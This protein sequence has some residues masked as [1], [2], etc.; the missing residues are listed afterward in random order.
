MKIYKNACKV[1]LIISL[2]I[3]APFYAQAQSK[4]PSEEF[5]IRGFHLDLRIQV[6]TPKALKAFADELSTMGMNTIVMEWEGTYPFKKHAVIANKYSYSRE[7]VKD[8]IDYCDNLGIQVIPLQQSLGHAEYILRN[9][10][11]SDLKAD[12]KDI[13]QINPLKMAESK[14]LFTDLFSDM[15]K[16]HNSDYIHIGGDET[17]ILDLCKGCKEKIAKEGESK[18]Y[19]DYMKMIANIVIDMGK[20]PV[21]WA[22][23][24]LKHPEAAKELPKETILVD[25]NYGWKTNHFGDIKNLQNLGFTFW[26]SPAIRS[27]PDNWYTTDWH[28]HFKNQQD[29]IPY[30]RK[31]GY[32]A[33]IMTSWSTSGLYGFTW[34]TGYDVVDMVQVRNVYPMSGFRILISSF[35]KALQTEKPIDPKSFVL[36]YGKDRFDLNTTDAQN[37]LDFLFFPPEL[38][39]HDKPV[40]S[41]SIS[42]MKRKYAK[43]RDPLKKIKPKNHKKEFAHFKLMADLRMHYLDFKEVQSTYNSES[44]RASQSPKLIK[45]LDRMLVDAKKLS[46]RFFKL[47]KGFLYD[48]ELKEQNRLRMQPIKVLRDRLTKLK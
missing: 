21:M 15:A 35:A 1:L 29:F 9:S 47:N 33:M 28:K 48:A 36:K 32:K 31:A 7:E 4:S 17:R 38:I 40:S 12:R 18:I 41:K 5:K 34:D 46:R 19:V 14:K 16:M 2:F 37:L 45:K 30:A 11:Y 8:F 43:V 42:E 25:W 24:I 22:D 10:R 26:G 3:A 39:V 23:M 13:S 44:F 20:T 6:M 27:H